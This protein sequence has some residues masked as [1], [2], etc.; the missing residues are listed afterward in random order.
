MVK[1]IEKAGNAVLDP[2][3]KR[4]DL[5]QRNA[6]L[7]HKVV[8][9]MKNSCRE[10]HEDLYQIGFIGLLKAANRYNPKTG[11]AFSS[12]AI[13]Y[14]RGEIQH[15]LRD[16]WQSVK[17]PRSALELRA[18]VK[19]IKKSLDSLGRNID[20]LQIALGLG[21][22][23]SQWRLLDNI[24]SNVTT[25]LDELV[26]EL[27]AEEVEKAPEIEEH[28][29]KL[30]FQQKNAILERFLIGLSIEEIANRNGVSTQLIRAR[31]NIGLS[32]IRREIKSNYY[33]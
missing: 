21:M 7:V 31:I 20:E 3:K 22:E 1:S 17:I 33:E 23:E 12:F 9:Q 32:K 2:I 27:K 4:N 14:I 11:N 13:P 6:K 18:K 26:Y 5:A 24:N 16:Q 15:Y 10:S 28:L 30:P 8:H 19:R 25:S 29:D